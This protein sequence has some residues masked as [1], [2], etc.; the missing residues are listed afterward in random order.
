MAGGV[1]VGFVGVGLSTGRGVLV[2]V[3][4]IAVGA[5]VFVG[6]VVAVGTDS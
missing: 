4:I 3:G 6:E 5:G 2:A 1:R